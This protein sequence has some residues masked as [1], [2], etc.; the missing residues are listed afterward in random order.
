MEHNKTPEHM[1][2]KRRKGDSK[3][4]LEPM[5]VEFQIALVVLL[6]LL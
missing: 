6:S 1:M 2:Y 5:S 4:H 3:W